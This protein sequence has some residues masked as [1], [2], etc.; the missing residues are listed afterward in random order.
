MISGSLLP[1][2]S[3]VNANNAGEKNILPYLSR[4]EKTCIIFGNYSNLALKK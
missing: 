4:D 3:I 1:G 2:R